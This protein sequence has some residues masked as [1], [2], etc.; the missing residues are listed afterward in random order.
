MYRNKHHR[1]YGT[2]ASSRVLLSAGHSPLRGP[3]EAA[4]GDGSK[5]LGASGHFGFITPV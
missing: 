2:N 1:A 3:V 5:T 4:A